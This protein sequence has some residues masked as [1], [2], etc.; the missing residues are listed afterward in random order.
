MKSKKYPAVTIAP[1]GD[2]CAAAKA[3]EGRRVLAVEAP[4]L[5]LSDC[6]QPHACQCRFKKYADRRDE[7]ETERRQRGVS[8]RSVLY[9]G[10]ERRRTGGRRQED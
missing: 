5:P 6:T 9:S 2:A 8:M 7:S 1:G 10:R 3:A 4:R